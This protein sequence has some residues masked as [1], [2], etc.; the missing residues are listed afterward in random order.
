MY[1]RQHYNLA[2]TGKL[3]QKSSGVGSGKSSVNN[4]RGP[5]GASDSHQGKHVVPTHRRGK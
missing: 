5:S 2:T 4:D 1:V 3:G